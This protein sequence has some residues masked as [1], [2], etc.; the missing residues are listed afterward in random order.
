M[1]ESRFYPAKA[2]TAADR[3]AITPSSFRWCRWTRLTIPCP[4]AHNAELWTER[5]PCGFVFDIKVYAALTHHP[6]EVK[7]LP[8]VVRVLLPA[9]EATAATDTPSH[10]R[11]HAD[12]EVHLL[13]QRGAIFK[14]MQIW[15]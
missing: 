10:I 3:L 8:E 1:T 11:V 7:R 4:Q 6:I 5:T 13:D 12:D 2:N 15:T 9:S 14:L